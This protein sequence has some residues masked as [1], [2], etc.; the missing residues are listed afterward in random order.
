MGTWAIAESLVGGLWAIAD[1][2]DKRLEKIA[3]LTMMLAIAP[4]TIEIWN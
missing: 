1:L 4:H 3:R 2:S